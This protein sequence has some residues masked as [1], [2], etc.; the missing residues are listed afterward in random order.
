MASDMGVYVVQREPDRVWVADC[1]NPHCGNGSH[2]VAESKRQSQAEA[3][4]KR[5]RS[6]I[7]AELAEV[8]ERAVRKASTDWQRLAEDRERRL[9]RATRKLFALRRY[10]RHEKGCRRYWQ[11]PCTCG[12]DGVLSPGMTPKETPSHG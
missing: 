11:Q 8:E 5:H 6:E 7:R 4:A 3:A 10:V 9:D 1:I 2:G 12:L